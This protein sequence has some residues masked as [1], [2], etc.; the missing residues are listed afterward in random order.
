MRLDSKTIIFFIIL[1][2]TCIGVSIIMDY[3]DQKIDKT[4]IHL[5]LFSIIFTIGFLLSIRGNN[6]EKLYLYHDE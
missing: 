4:S 2:L 3:L 6:N 5:I 1:N